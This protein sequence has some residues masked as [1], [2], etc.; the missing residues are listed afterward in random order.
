MAKSRLSSVQRTMAACRKGGRMVWKIEQWVSFSKPGAAPRPGYPMGVRRDAFEFIDIIAIDTDKIVAIQAC[1]SGRKAH[2]D[3]IIAC[4]YALPWLKAGGT[5]ELWSWTKK[6]I[7]RGGVAIRWTAKIEQITETDFG[8]V[9]YYGK[10]ENKQEE[11]S[12]A[13]W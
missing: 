8:K 3:K 2:W 7:K 4:E 1:T 10:Q 11:G 5:I 13:I 9:G 6:K 12:E